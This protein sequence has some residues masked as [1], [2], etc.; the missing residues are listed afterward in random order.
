MRERAASRYEG[1]TYWTYN[2]RKCGGSQ[3]MLEI[4]KRK[5]SISKNIVAAFTLWRDT[6]AWRMSKGRKEIEIGKKFYGQDNTE[7]STS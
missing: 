4:S 1:M 2:W 5:I 7:E 6:N 3:R